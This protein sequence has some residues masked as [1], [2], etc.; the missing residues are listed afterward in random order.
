MDPAESYNVAKFHSQ[1]VAE[2]QRELDGLMPSFPPNV[3]EFYAALRQNVGS[4][5]TPAGAEPRP[6]LTEKPTV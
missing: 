6:E 3:V 2:L 4:A 1:K 5:A